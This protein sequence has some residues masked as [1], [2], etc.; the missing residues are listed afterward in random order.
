MKSIKKL[1]LTTG[2]SCG[3]ALACNGAQQLAN[4]VTTNAS[5]MILSAT[6]NQLTSPNYYI[7]T[8]P[9]AYI[10][11]QPYCTL[12]NAS[13]NT[14]VFDAS[15]DGSHW[16][17]GVMRVLGGS[18]TVTTTNVCVGTITNT[19]PGWRYPIW[20]VNVENP[21]SY[22]TISPTLLVYKADP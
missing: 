18:Q 14:F 22:A 8:G 13:T 19:P 17:L 3:L 16:T 15:V 1:F 7:V 4:Q 10:V 6:T 20:R 2:L 5:S 12:T 21:T 9:S 11:F